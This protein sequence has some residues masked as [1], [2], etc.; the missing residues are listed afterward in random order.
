MLDWHVVIWLFN[1]RHLGFKCSET[2]HIPRQ[3]QAQGCLQ[4]L[5]I[6][7]GNIPLGMKAAEQTGLGGLLTKWMRVASTGI[8][9]LATL[10]K[11]EFDSWFQGVNRAGR[12]S[13]N[14]AQTS[15]L[16]AQQHQPRLRWLLKQWNKVLSCLLWSGHI[17]GCLSFYAAIPMVTP[18]AYLEYQRSVSFSLG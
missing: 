8:F 1:V 13:I 9:S 7:R 12:T 5:Y 3:L 14:H 10:M 15:V 6:W 2:W 18:T 4:L 16:Q 11:W 17:F